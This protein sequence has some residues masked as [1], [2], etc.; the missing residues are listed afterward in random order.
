MVVEGRDL[1]LSSPPPKLINGNKKIESYK[2]GFV[3]LA[4]PFFAFSE[5]LPCPKMKVGG[6]REGGREA[7][8]CLPATVV[9]RER[10]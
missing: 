3:N 7:C 1:A 9:L 8:G 2:N 6:R 10:V 4:L 5:P